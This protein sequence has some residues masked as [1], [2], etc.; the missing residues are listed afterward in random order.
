M[1]GASAAARA[2]F[3]QVRGKVEVRALQDVHRANGEPIE[4]QPA[5]R[6]TEAH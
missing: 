3:A 2:I 5:E 6:P 1:T 4:G